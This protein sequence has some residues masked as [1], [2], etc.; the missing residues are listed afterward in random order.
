MSKF[1]AITFLIIGWVL[2]I[3]AFFK[4]GDSQTILFVWA[5]VM[6]MWSWTISDHI[7]LRDEIRKVR[8][9]DTSHR[10]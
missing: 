4:D 8:D 9:D 6:F 10:F 2:T 1:W 5:A 3:S 7:D